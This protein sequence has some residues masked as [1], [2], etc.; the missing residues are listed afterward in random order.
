MEPEKSCRNQPHAHC[1]YINVVGELLG[2]IH[3]VVCERLR[4]Y[5]FMISSLKHPCSIAISVKGHMRSVHYWTLNNCI[6]DYRSY[7]QLRN[8]L[9]VKFD[10]HESKKETR[11]K[12]VLC[13]YCGVISQADIPNV[14]HS[15]EPE[16]KGSL[17]PL[18]L[19]L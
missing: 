4:R 14:R 3:V 9:H 18:S 10:L 5:K 13:H 2:F 17:A 11:G 12:Q 6:R 8:Q 16:G 19:S 7:K 1:S 15:P